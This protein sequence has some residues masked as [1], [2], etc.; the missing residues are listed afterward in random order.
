MSKL[1]IEKV[2]L[3]LSRRV[4]SLE[5]SPTTAVMQEAN[6]LKR[7]GVDVIDFGPGEPDFATPENIKA[8][9]HLAISQNFTKYT[10]V[11]GIVPLKQALVDRYKRDWGAD[12]Q[13]GEIIFCAGG[14]QALF[15]LALALFEEGDEVIVPAPY[16][17]TFPEQ[18][19]LAGA[20]PV[21]L[22]VPEREEFIL[23]ARMLE[24]VI[25]DRTRAIIVNSPNNPTGAVIPEE[26]IRKLVDLAR[27]QNIMLISDETYERF[28]YRTDRA[29]SAAALWNKAREHVI[30][31]SAVS[32]T[33]AMTGWRI[34]YALGPS[35]IISAAANIQSHATSNPASVSQKAALEAI[36]GDQSSVEEMKAEYRRRRDFAHAELVKIPGVRCDLPEGAFYLFPNVSDYLR[37]NV[38]DSVALAKYLLNE[39]G[40]AIVP[41]SAF[42]AEG[43]VRIS[44]AT[45]MELLADGIGRMRVALEKL[46][47]G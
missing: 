11:A 19:R 24:P 8:A 40:V 30:V 31:V 28:S 36:T 1:K 9:A 13:P 46:V 27:A 33:Y 21:F 35:T 17:V 3:R 23:R 22:N 44:Y 6:R 2:P 16:W 26:E 5:I 7:Q 47:S 25:S 4:Q 18:V 29:F 37:P 32:K 41:G 39:A 43:Y 14:K 45:S 42:G 10:E 15:N 38:P 12:Y 34:G 20:R